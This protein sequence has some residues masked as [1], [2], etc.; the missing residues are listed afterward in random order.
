MYFV[1]QMTMAH[2]I[3]LWLETRFTGFESWFGRMFVIE[4]GHIQCSKLDCVCDVCGLC[5]DVYGTVRYKEP[6]KLFDKSRA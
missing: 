3:R 6:L 2:S 4:V 5:S 1:L